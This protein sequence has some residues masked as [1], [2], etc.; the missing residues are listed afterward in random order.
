MDTTHFPIAGVIDVL[1]EKG[2]MQKIF[3]RNLLAEKA[4]GPFDITVHVSHEVDCEISGCTVLDSDSYFRSNRMISCYSVGSDKFKFSISGFDG[5]DIKIAV[6]PL[7]DYSCFLNK[8]LLPFLDF[9]LN[10]K[11]KLLLQSK[12]VNSAVTFPETVQ[13]WDCTQG[14]LVVSNGY[15]SDPFSC[16]G[17]PSICSFGDL[18]LRWPASD[19]AESLFWLTE[20]YYLYFR[21]LLCSYMFLYPDKS[22][23]KFKENYLRAVRANLGT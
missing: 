10:T 14:F 19:I 15:V 6:S 18:K 7:A 8:I 22:I 21:D 16:K 2:L 9:L 13:K 5:G 23:S 17:G 3:D 12:L 11:D 1:G 20:H 4:T